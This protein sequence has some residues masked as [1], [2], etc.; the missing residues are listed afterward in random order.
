MLFPYVLALNNHT[1]PSDSPVHFLSVLQD[2]QPLRGHEKEQREVFFILKCKP[3]LNDLK[4]HLFLVH[5]LN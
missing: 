2:S 1:N 4:L 5:A 3:V